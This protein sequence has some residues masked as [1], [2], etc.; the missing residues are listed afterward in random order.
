MLHTPEPAATQL[1][2]TGREAPTGGLDS[3]S[4][5][6]A[7]RRLMVLPASGQ[8]EADSGDHQTESVR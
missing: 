6:K 4:H 8:A 1:H 3:K 2:M 5:G 7:P